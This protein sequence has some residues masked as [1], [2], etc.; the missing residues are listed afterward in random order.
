MKQGRNLEMREIR[1]TAHSGL[2]VLLLGILMA[3]FFVL[4]CYGWLLFRSPSLGKIAGLSWAL[5][6]DIGNLSF[7]ASTPT[8]CR[9][10]LMPDSYVNLAAR[11]LHFS[12]I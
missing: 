6:S 3:G 2:A 9:P 5:V 8:V 1:R 10:S 4:T 11:S 12:T 7:T